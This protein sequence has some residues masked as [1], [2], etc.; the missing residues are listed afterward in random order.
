MRKEPLT[1]IHSPP[2]A[3]VLQHPW[4][5]EPQPQPPPR[6]LAS[7]AAYEQGRAPQDSSAPH[8]WVLHGRFRKQSFRTPNAFVW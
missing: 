6:L 7:R 1:L 5:V 3:V 8:S 2:E 4:R